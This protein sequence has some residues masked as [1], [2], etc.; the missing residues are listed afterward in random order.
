[1]RA[2]NAVRT[3]TASSELQSKCNAISLQQISA[4][5]G[6][7]LMVSSNAYPLAAI[8]STKSC[9]GKSSTCVAFSDTDSEVAEI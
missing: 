2:L 3:D 9:A 4:M 1:M 6:A 7:S 5:I 8:C